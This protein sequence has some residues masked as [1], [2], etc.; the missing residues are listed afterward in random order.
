MD[1]QAKILI[2]DDEP[3]NV[4]YLEQELEDL[5]YDTISA[6]NGRVALEQ[7]AAE[8]PDVILLD[9]MMPEMD[10]FQVLAHLK[11]DQTWRDIPVIVISALD[12]MDMMA[13]QQY[14]ICSQQLESGSGHLMNV[15]CNY[16]TS[17]IPLL[18]GV[19]LFVMDEELDTLPTSVPFNDL[20]AIQ[21]I[22]DAGDVITAGGVT[23]A[24]DL[25]LYLVERLARSH[26]KARISAQMDY[27]YLPAQPSSGN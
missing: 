9:I 20:D 13:L 12:D 23:S 22:V 2:V 3:F 24:I 1:G 27:P 16:G 10:G 26:A 11:A 5:D 25:G 21:R 18:F 6:E 8:A 19:E 17:I 14:G 4:D 15:R 7:V